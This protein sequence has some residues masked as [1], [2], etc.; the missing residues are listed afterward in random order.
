MKIGIFTV[1]FAGTRIEEVLKY[2]KKHGCEMAEIGT[3]NFPG[4]AHCPTDLLLKKPAELEKYKKMMADSGLKISALSCHGNPLHPNKKIAKEH[5]QGFRKAVEL[6]ERLGVDRVVCFSGCPGDNDKASYPNWVIA[7]W[8][9][10]HVELL[11]WQ[12]EKKIIPYWEEEVKFAR[13]HGINKICLEMHPAFAVYNP[14]T[15]LRLRDAVGETI[16]AN[17]DPSHLFWQGID[18]VVAVKHLGA[19]IYHVH[20]K[21]TK[22]NPATTA[23]NG[24]L[25]T[26][27]YSEVSARSWGFR[28]VG[29][30]HDDSFWKD[31]IKAL[32]S[33]GYDYVLS[34]EHEDPLLGI[35]EGF[36]KAAAFLKGIITK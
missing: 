27:P 6:A 32:Q 28:T 3:G 17:F 7:A 5:R 25:D 36:E 31:F 13:Q 21:D 8:P 35:N 34:I 15:L 16:G 29:D 2:V 26:T 4:N 9:G 11:K 20:A 23:V 19:A 1:V 14:H 12:W 30:G 33:V 18:P 10:E 22:I 24:V